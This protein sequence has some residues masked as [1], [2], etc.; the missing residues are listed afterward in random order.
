MSFAFRMQGSRAKRIDVNQSADFNNL[1]A[2]AL[3]TVITS[4]TVTVTGNFPASSAISVSVSGSGGTAQ[5]QVNSGSFTASAGTI[6]PTDTVTLRVTTHADWLGRRSIVTINI[7]GFTFSW[8]VT[9]TA[10]APAFA[11]PVIEIFD[12]AQYQ[13]T[14]GSPSITTIGT[15]YNTTNSNT[16]FAVTGATGAADNYIAQAGTTNT[17][18][19]P[20]GSILGIK[21]SGTYTNHLYQATEYNTVTQCYVNVHESLDLPS[22]DN[23]LTGLRVTDSSG[24]R[25]PDDPALLAPNNAVLYDNTWNHSNSGITSNNHSLTIYPG[26]I[27]FDRFSITLQNFPSMA[28]NGLVQDGHPAPTGGGSLGGAGNYVTIEI[29]WKVKVTNI[30]TEAEIHNIDHLAGTFQFMPA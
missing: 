23:L 10:P 15:S 1:T 21:I 9:T 4:N 14:G 8:A 22:G 11:S 2:Q 5:Y 26:S 27:D 12:P 13:A 30:V 24:G 16:T 17:L 20:G 29:V 25:G 18:Q 19:W 7:A 6:D 28:T 3:N